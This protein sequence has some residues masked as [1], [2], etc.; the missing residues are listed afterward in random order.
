M[1]LKQIFGLKTKFL[2]A[3]LAV[4]KGIRTRLDKVDKARVMALKEQNALDKEIMK[5]RKSKL[6][7]AEMKLIM[8]KMKRNQQRLKVLRNNATTLTKG[9]GKA[10]QLIARSVLTGRDLT[11]IPRRKKKMTMKS[12]SKKKK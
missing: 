10:S 3:K 4:T 1:V 8:N 6:S 11:R 2:R 12:K 5:A 9:L 7:K